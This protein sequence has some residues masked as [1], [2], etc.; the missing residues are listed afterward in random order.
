MGMGI[1]HH[2]RCAERRITKRKSN[3]NPLSLLTRAA[4]YET[5]FSEM[6]NIET[7]W[8][9]IHTQAETNEGLRNLMD[10]CIMYYRLL[11]EKNNGG[12]DGGG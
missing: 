9:K 1:W 4:K 7:L 5:E 2:P 3:M 11:E 12:N 10:Q 8:F 6:R